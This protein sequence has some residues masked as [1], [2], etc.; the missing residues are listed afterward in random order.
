M[1]NVLLTL[2]RSLK[3]NDLLKTQLSVLKSRL[4]RAIDEID[5]TNQVEYTDYL[6][7]LKEDPW[8]VIAILNSESED[9]PESWDL[10]LPIPKPESVPEFDGF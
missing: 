5:R 3:K 9:L 2:N 7:F 8:E 4:Q 10:C 1:D 6:I